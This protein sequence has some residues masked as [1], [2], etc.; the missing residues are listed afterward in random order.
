MVKDV[1]EAEL[2]VR[3]LGVEVDCENMQHRLPEDKL[4]DVEMVLER[5][6]ARGPEESSLP[7]KMQ[8]N[9]CESWRCAE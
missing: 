1:S 6:Q 8:R 3:Y 5:R 2:K 4:M 9:C 7:N